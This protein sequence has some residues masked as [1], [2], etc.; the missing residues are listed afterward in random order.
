VEWSGERAGQP[1]RMVWTARFDRWH[2][3]SWGTA[4]VDAVVEGGASEKVDHG[5]ECM[6]SGE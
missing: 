4:I 2:A 1:V 6:L 3:D 5:C